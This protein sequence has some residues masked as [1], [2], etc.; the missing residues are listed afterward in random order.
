[1]RPVS[2]PAIVP[3]PSPAPPP[4][5][6]TP[7]AP[8]ESSAGLAGQTLDDDASIPR[9][10]SNSSASYAIPRESARSQKHAETATPAPRLATS[11]TRKHSAA[12][13]EAKQAGERV[14][15]DTPLYRSI[16]GNGTLGRGPARRRSR[17]KRKR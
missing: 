1:M 17:R 10:V 3:T 16:S 6:A 14:D 4:H 2:E 9:S 5:F 11:S 8:T 15:D 13:Q 7:G 12:S